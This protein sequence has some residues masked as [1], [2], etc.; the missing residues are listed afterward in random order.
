MN[1]LSELLLIDDNRSEITAETQRKRHRVI[2]F[3]SIAISN[4]V[5]GEQGK[6][7]SQY[8]TFVQSSLSSS[9]SYHSTALKR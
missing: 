3:P 6:A 1:E 4:E 9:S 7:T 2:V 8:G 5:N